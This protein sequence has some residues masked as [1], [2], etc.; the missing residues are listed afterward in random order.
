[1]NR[2]KSALLAGLH[3]LSAP[4]DQRSMM[5]STHESASILGLL[6]EAEEF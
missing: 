5:Y 3:S 6:C 1:M 4:W 2:S